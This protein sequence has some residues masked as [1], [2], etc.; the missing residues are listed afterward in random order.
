M[1]IIIVPFFLKKIPSK[2]LLNE[3]SFDPSSHFRRRCESAIY[4]S[5]Q[6]FKIYFKVKVKTRG[7][8]HHFGKGGAC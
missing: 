2:N 5:K 6:L 3:A 1:T 4:D 7:T 8:T